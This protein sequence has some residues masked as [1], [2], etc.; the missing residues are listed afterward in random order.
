MPE[1]PVRFV[2]FVSVTDCVL[3]ARQDARGAAA[4][5]GFHE[6]NI[7]VLVA[8]GLLPVLAQNKI[9]KNAVKYFSTA[10]LLE[11]AGSEVWLHRATQAVVDHQFRRNHK[12]LRTHKRNALADTATEQKA[13]Q[14]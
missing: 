7:P 5:L 4:I 3:A 1:P 6:A 13:P 14:A 9:A 8:K 2:K 11:L 12:S 10:K